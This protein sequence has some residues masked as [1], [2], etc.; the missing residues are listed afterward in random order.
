MK[1][2]T[3]QVTMPDGKVEKKRGMDPP[4]FAVIGLE[5]EVDVTWA[6]EE[7]VTPLG[8]VLVRVVTDVKVK[9]GSK[10]QWKL[11]CWA[12]DEDEAD[13]VTGLSETFGSW[14]DIRTRRGVQV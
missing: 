10:P 3:V 5:Q 8:D 11:I 2:K 13:A 6:D 12:R 4:R 7:R 9:E 1:M 14:L